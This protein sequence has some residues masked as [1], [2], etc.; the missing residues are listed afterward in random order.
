MWMI[1]RAGGGGDSSGGGAVQRVIHEL[2]GGSSYPTLTKTNYSDWALLMKMKLKA[3]GLWSAVESG[4][5][6]HQEDMMALD[7]LS[8]TVPPEMVST[9]A[10]KDTAKSA[11]ETTKMMWVGDDRVR[12]AAAQHLLCQFEMAEIKL[13][14]SIEDYSMRLSGMVQHLA[15]LGETVAEPKV[16]GKFL[17]SVPHKYKQIVVAIQTLLD[18]ETLT[19]ANVTGRLK[20]VEDELEAPP[21]SVNHAGKLY[22][23][24]EACEE[25]WR[26]REG[27]NASRSSGRGGGGRGANH[28]RGRGRGN[29]GNDRDSSGSNPPGLGKV[30]RDQCR[31]CGKKGHW[32]RDC[33]SKPKKEAA[34]TTQEE[35]LLMLV[36][37]MPEIQTN[38]DHQA[39]VTQDAAA[40]HLVHL[41]EQ[42]VFAQLG[43]RE[44]HDHRSWICDTGA[45]NHMSGSQSAFTELDTAVQATVR[46]GDDSVTEIKGRGTVEF[47][48]KDGEHHT[49][50]GAYYIPRLTANIVSLG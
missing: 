39:A 5:G 10:S 8:S 25:K 31:K 24:E 46:F 30:G 4:G 45:T 27:S 16:V 34:F 40:T 33:R 36:T 26:L 6:D 15:M 20:A 18:V 9:V 43:V 32:A 28:G 2:G 7:V 14:E 38:G 23:T 1:Q 29:G 47:L 35:E 3:R 42:K 41:Y 11:W 22:L 37:A 19:L 13:E 44:E 49:F 21:A 17:R 50:A 48:Y 12:A